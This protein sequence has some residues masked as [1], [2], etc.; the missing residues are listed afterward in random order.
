STAGQLGRELET[1]RA[2]LQR[3]VLD[4]PEETRASAAAMRRVVAEQIEALSELNAIVRAQPDTYDVSPRPAPR[5]P[6]RS[7]AEPAREPEPSRSEPRRMEPRYPET[8]ILS[9][10]AAPQPAPAPAAKSPSERLNAALSQSR[11]TRPAAETAPPA[12]PAAATAEPQPQQGGW[13]RDVL[14]NASA[15]QASAQKPTSLTTLTEEIA[16]AVDDRNLADAWNRY[17]N[18]E[19]GVFGRRLYTIAGQATFED[20]RRKIASDPEF[21]RTATAYMAE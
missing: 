10:P 13:L 11:A 1:T 3:S 20:V 8:A 21:Q 5:R 6:S 12:A 18:G 17:Q 4:L 7:E 19:T 15:N 16:R 14:R 9:R 2:E